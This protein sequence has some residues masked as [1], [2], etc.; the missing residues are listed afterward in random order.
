MTRDAGDRRLSRRRVLQTTGALAGVSLLG[1]SATPAAGAAY[2]TTTGKSEPQYEKLPAED[3]Y[4]ETEFVV[5]GETETPTIYGSII[6]PDTDEPVPVIATYSPYNDIRSPQG[7][8]GS[9]AADGVADYFVPRGY[10]RAMFDVVGTRN[11]EGCYD[12]GGIRERKT[13]A[14]VVE[15]LGTREWSS[16]KVGMI[17]GSYDGTTQ[18]A[19]AIEDPDH[20][21]T[22][23][24]QVAIDRWY[25]Y[26]FGGG[27]RYFLNNEYPTDEGF[28]T[29]LAFDFGFGLIPPMNGGDTDQFTSTF[30]DRI[31]PCDEIEHTNR[32]YEFD[33]VYDAFWDER[34]YRA[35]AENVSCSVFIEGGWLD[36]NVKH[37]DSTRFF[38]ALPD[39]VPKKLVMGQW[40]HAASQFEDAQDIRHAWFDYWL[41]GLDTGVMDLPR[42]DT[43]L[44]T[45]ERIQQADWPPEGT[46]DVEVSLTRTAS[47]DPL[48]LGLEG[49]SLP[50]YDD[51]TPPVTE[52][53]M[54][55]GSNRGY[56]TFKTGQL[57][58]SVRISGSPLLDLLVAS[59][60]DSTHFTPV[61]FDE[62][63]DGS[64]EVITRGFLNARNR[65]GLDQS[66]PVP[67]DDT[68]RAPVELWDVDWELPAGHRLGLVVASDNADWALDDPD[69]E[70]TNELLLDAGGADGSRLCLPVSEGDARATTLSVSGTRE[71][72]GSVFTG[73]QTNQIDLTVKASAPAVVR[74]YVPGGWTVLDAGDVSHTEPASDGQG[75]YVYFDT[76]PAETVAVTYFVET[77]AGA[78]A[79]GSYDFGPVEARAAA[80]QV[81]LG[82]NG[83]TD[84]NTVVGQHT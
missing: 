69:G 55:S 6:R 3:H 49:T 17:G 31:T 1:L 15:Y 44:N 79:T 24:P 16:G 32:A 75:K 30:G 50:V 35:K 53:E 37:W 20:L 57:A 2:E 59:S 43:Q 14:Q 64:T 82:V 60:D 51:V 5:D 45:G 68:Y 47:A 54:F 19:A 72:D 84:E 28:D 25:D 7:E 38:M 63:P 76:D 61:L 67:T 27:I 62:A 34:D 21:T 41:K 40:N 42:V 8:A 10:A 52:E 33:P 70:S 39:D 12:Y 65:D 80:G 83:T 46:R 81:W 22:I 71:D 58:E 73:G 13:A 36:H 4:V 48:E 18:L 77:P 29:P 66:E 56:L 26:A 23:I 78:T 74:D 9:T 11:S